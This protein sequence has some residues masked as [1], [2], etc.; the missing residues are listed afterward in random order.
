MESRVQGLHGEGRAGAGAG[1]GVTELG[2]GRVQ[3]GAANGLTRWCGC[4]RGS[5]W[6]LRIPPGEAL[7]ACAP[8]SVREDRLTVW[9]RGCH[10]ALPG[11]GNW[12]QA[13]HRARGG[14][15]GRVEATGEACNHAVAR[16]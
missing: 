6:L 9:G 13:V 16:P 7:W 10:W 8:R 1:A 11:R 3:D 5:F 12:A 2:W 14:G 15:A 4:R